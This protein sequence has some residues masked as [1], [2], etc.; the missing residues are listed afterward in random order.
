MTDHTQHM[1]RAMELARF[2]HGRTGTNP[3]VGCVILNRDG[4]VISEAAT[5]DG[6]KLH[7]EEAALRGL[8]EGAA[9]GGTAYVTLEPCRERSAGG[10]SCSE[11]LLSAGIGVVCIAVRDP[12][13]NGAGGLARLREAGVKIE[14]GILGDEAAGF[15]AEFFSRVTQNTN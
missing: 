12:H 5:G 4:R 9:M 3:S 2:Q 11:H 10:A 7:A 15:Y 1:K 8:P 14:L 6:G 13:P